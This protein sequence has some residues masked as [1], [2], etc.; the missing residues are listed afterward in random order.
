VK[1]LQHCSAFF[2]MDASFHRQNPIVLLQ[3]TY[4]RCQGTCNPLELSSITSSG[5]ERI[6]EPNKTR[7]GDTLLMLSYVH[8]VSGEETYFRQYLQLCSVDPRTKLSQSSE[9]MRHASK[10]IGVPAK[11]SRS[12]LHRFT[13]GVTQNLIPINEATHFLA[14]LSYGRVWCS[15]SRLSFAQ[16]VPLGN[17]RTQQ[18]KL[19]RQLINVCF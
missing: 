5:A 2:W 1:K 10:I 18:E 12:A 7:V 13:A 14:L 9:S 11:S 19:E 3:T 17:L 15:L 4:T 8:F 6:P 16:H